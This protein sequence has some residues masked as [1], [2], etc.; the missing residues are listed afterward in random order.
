M[1]GMDRLRCGIELV[2]HRAD[3]RGL[4]DVLG[5]ADSLLVRGMRDRGVGAV[6]EADRGRVQGHGREFIG[7]ASAHG[8]RS[9]R[10]PSALQCTGQR[11]VTFGDATGFSPHRGDRGVA[12][13]EKC[14]TEARE[15]LRDAFTHV[16][17][18]VG[19]RPAINAMRCRRPSRTRHPRYRIPRHRVPRT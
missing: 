11:I 2:K 9:E 5:N 10:L 1:R 3:E 18:S 4:A 8:R 12:L 14:D 7:T 17:P 16:A 15:E 13:G 6:T 19:F